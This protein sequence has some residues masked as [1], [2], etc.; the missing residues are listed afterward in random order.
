VMTNAQRK[1][2]LASMLAGAAAVM[3]QQPVHASE[4][5]CQAAQFECEAVCA[6]NGGA[7]SCSMEEAS[8]PWYHVD[9]YCADLSYNGFYYVC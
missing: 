1:L 4:T 5:C 7:G 2:I 3:D 8:A 6:N 9:C